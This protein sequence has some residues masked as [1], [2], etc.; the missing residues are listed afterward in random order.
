MSS[1][2]LILPELM[3]TTDVMNASTSDS[4]SQM[5]TQTLN[6]I[7]YYLVECERPLP[8]ALKVHPWYE[9]YQVESKWANLATTLQAA[10]SSRLTLMTACAVI[11]SDLGGDADLSIKIPGTFNGGTPPAAGRYFRSVIITSNVGAYGSRLH[12]IRVED[13]DRVIAAAK[14]G[15]TDQQM[16]AAGF[17]NYP[18]LLNFADNELTETSNVKRGVY[19]APSQALKLT[20]IKADLEFIPAGMYFK[21]HF[22]GAATTSVYFNFE[23]AGTQSLL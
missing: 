17:P 9:K 23:W 1:V 3:V 15:L 11:T 6:G 19:L 12:S 13:A 7:N 8:D 14:G 10:P 5:P 20:P 22:T 4:K 18:V 2:F 21:A 16:Q